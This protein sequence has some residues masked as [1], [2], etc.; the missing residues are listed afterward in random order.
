MIDVAGEL[1]GELGD[2]VRDMTVDDLDN[3]ITRTTGSV[4]IHS[5]QF[6]T[7]RSQKWR[8]R[9][10]SKLKGVLHL[11]MHAVRHHSSGLVRVQRYQ[12]DDSQQALTKQA[13]DSLKE[14][15]NDEEPVAPLAKR[16][17]SY[18]HHAARRK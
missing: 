12:D 17:R 3:A 14:P 15:S 18:P 10:R 13:E 4:Q 6:P 8:S 2:S 9:P 5:D 11:P 1:H 7:S 16:P